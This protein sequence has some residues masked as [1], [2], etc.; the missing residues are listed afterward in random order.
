[1]SQE[2][3]EIVR[4]AIG[5]MSQDAAED[6]A[7]TTSVQRLAPGVEFEEDPRFPEAGTYRGR[8]EVLRYFTEFV[9]QF[10]DFVLTVEDLGHRWGRRARLPAHPRPGRQAA[11]LRRPAGW[12]FTVRDGEVVRIRADLDRAEA[13][14]AAGLQQ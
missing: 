9:S 1:M 2:N 6:E 3:V 13:L 4:G 7:R 5:P 8:A 10:E 12:I 11:P 14:A